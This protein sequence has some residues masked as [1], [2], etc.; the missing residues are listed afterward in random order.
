MKKSFIIYI[1]ILF[2]SVGNLLPNTGDAYIENVQ[3]SGSTFS[4]EFHFKRTDAWTS[5]FFQDALGISTASFNFNIGALNAPVVVIEPGGPLD[6]DNY[7]VTVQIIGGKCIVDIPISLIVLAGVLPLN[8][9][10]KL[11]TVSMNITDVNQTAQLSWDALNTGFF[12]NADSTVTTTLL[13]SS[14]APLP[15]ELNSFTAEA[16][17]YNVIL[18]WQTATEINNY[19]FDVERKVTNGDWSKIGFVEGAG[20][21]ISP[22]SYK[23]TDNKPIGG[24][25]FIYRLKQLDTDGSYEYSDEVEVEI[26]P[27]EFALYQNYP[28]P[29][30]PSTKIRYQLPQESKVII[31]IYDM[32]GSEV[33]TLLNEQ[34]E[35]GVYEV[36]FNASHL[37]SGTYIYRLV[38]GSFVVT[39]KMLL[40]K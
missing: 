25:K 14:N 11:L 29:F 13:G 23:F 36:D 2:L 27:T 26:I 39:R 33:I 40:M 7:N 12:D 24:S 3:V 10:V 18:N 1:I 16:N 31:K 35:P 6:N 4:W 28:N 32:L 22:K 21:T 15:V 34:K 5:G 37:S 30:N 9:K 17:D 20:N 8:V 38:A 19:G